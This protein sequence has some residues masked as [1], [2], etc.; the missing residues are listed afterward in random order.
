M[1]PSMIT[2][3]YNFFKLITAIYWSKKVLPLISYLSNKSSFFFFFSGTSIYSIAY[4]TFKY[5]SFICFGAANI[6]KWHK[7]RK[8]MVKKL[9]FVNFLHSHQ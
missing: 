3:T 6:S 2:F 8:D 1:Y 5:F 4:L 9:D 7:K